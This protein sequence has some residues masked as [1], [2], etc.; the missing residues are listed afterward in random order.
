MKK[1]KKILVISRTPWD[2]NNSFGNSFSNIFGG[3]K[4]LEIANIYCSAG[5]PN[6][7]V[8]KKYFQIDEKSILKNCINSNY[9]AG[10]EIFDDIEIIQDDFSSKKFFKINRL[11]IFFWIREFIWLLGRWK[12][13]ELDDFVL[14]FKPDVIFIPI[15]KWPYMC[16]VALY[17]VNKFNIR[18]IGYITDDN[19]TLKQYSLDPSYWIERIIF[20]NYVKKI[21]EKCKLLYVI[22][23]IQKLEYEKIFKINCKVLY[24]GFL[25]HENVNIKPI[26]KEIIITYTGNLGAG[27]YNTLLKFSK[28]IDEINEMSSNHIK[29][30]VFVYSHTNLSSK[31][32]KF[33]NKFK[34][35]F[36]KGALPITQ[37]NEIQN[38]AD[39]L[40]HF[41]GFSLRNKLEVKYSFSTKI[42]DY[43]S[44]GKCI[45]A[46]GP[47]GVNSIDY[48]NDNNLGYSVN[49]DNTLKKVLLSLISD[50]SLIEEKGKSAFNNGKNIHNIY[51]IQEELLN[52]LTRII[53]E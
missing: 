42:V 21:I 24:K 43:I 10:R 52:D 45:I 47:K 29:Y 19:Y 40:V 14:E 49:D 48:I 23:D 5:R 22:S 17:I 36:Y 44:K 26:F 6:N 46:F 35:T 28:I 33:L 4:N 1:N 16:N 39:I 27:R 25:F 12:S 13:K 3:I 37:I 32:I 50:T 18:V 30:Q 7:K 11:R 2:N 20:R 9:K 34:S 8:V 53:G 51:T 41:E 15:Y 31:Q 38:L